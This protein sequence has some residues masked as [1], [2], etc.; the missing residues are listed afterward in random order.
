M[1]VLFGN[2]ISSFVAI[3]Q[4]HSGST[5]ITD[6]DLQAIAANFRHNARLDALKL[7][8]LGM[9]KLLNPVLFN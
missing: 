2:L 9:S 1:S 8:Y 7:M 6:E 4:L 5:Y 3:G